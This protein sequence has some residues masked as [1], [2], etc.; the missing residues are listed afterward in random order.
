MMPVRKPARSWAPWFREIVDMRRWRAR[1]ERMRS[2]SIETG[3][4]DFGQST[5]L[6]SFARQV[7][8]GPE[9]NGP[10]YPDASPKLPTS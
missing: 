8:D 10:S 7:F 4:V 6:I 1:F 3:T 2:L 5:Q 9:R